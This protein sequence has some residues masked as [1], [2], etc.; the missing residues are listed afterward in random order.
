MRHDNHIVL[1]W[2]SKGGAG[3]SVTAAA[4]TLH[5]TKPV[6]LVDLDGDAASILG[7][8]RS[9]GGIGVN[10]WL[11]HHD[12]EPA[13]LT[14]LVDHIDDKTS[15]LSAGVGGDVRY[16]NPQRVEQL[17]NW[18]AEQP[19]IVIIDAGTGPPPQALVDIAGRNVMVTRADYL[20]LSKPDVVAS[21]PDEI[22]LVN[23]PG[24]AIDRRDIE[25]AIKAPVNTVI[26]LNPVIAR[27][28]DAGMF[29][30]NRSLE[31]ATSNLTNPDISP[32]RLPAP[33]IDYGMRWTSNSTDG[34]FRVSYNP[35]THQLTA[36][37]NSTHSTEVLGRYD[38]IASVD[39][40]LE[41]WADKHNDE[42]GLDWLEEQVGVDAPD[43]DRPPGPPAAPAPPPPS[44]DLGLSLT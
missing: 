9:R 17:A 12:V 5:E 24:R 43:F 35:G 19:G 33:E 23:E 36:T 14:E 31:R 44:H 34:S 3:T 2:G 26:E 25:R 15:V 38:D 4:A 22:V 13:R 7:A 27:S 6:L 10:D 1:M 21:N 11:A 16:A 42:G 18:I 20:A 40:A 30:G 41:G 39:R 37:N 8:P 32:D 28:V 29:L